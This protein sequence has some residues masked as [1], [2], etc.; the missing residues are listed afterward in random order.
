MNSLQTLQAKM[1]KA[2]LKALRARRKAIKRERRY[3]KALFK[4]CEP[5]EKDT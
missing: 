4:A 5:K 1:E 2:Y 3:R